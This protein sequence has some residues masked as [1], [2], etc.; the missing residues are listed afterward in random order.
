MPLSHKTEETTLEVGAR[1]SALSQAQTKEILKLLK[2][3]H[4]KVRFFCNWMSS[5]GDRD[6]KTSLQN[7]DKTDFFT[8]DVDTALKERV[9]R[10]AIHSAKDLPAPLP[11][12]LS[13]IALTYPLDPRDMLVPSQKYSGS[14]LPQRPIVGTSSER[15]EAAVK[16]KFPEA[17]CREIRGSILSR[18]E[19]L[20]SGDFD[21]I[22]APE[23]ALLRLGLDQRSRSPLEGIPAPLQGQLA[24]L[25]RSDDSEMEQL[26]RCIDARQR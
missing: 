26:F 9:V 21:A 6:Q 22:V 5:P 14:D 12:E 11:E 2:K 1:D 20:D 4:P 19:Q 7:L 8:K 18:L 10:I 17:I 16:K 15:R 24:V 3:H 13:I 23:C 25:A